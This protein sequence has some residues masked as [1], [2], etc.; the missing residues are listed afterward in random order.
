MTNETDMLAALPRLSY[1]ARQRLIRKIRQLDA[2]EG[3][4]TK[5]AS[6]DP[7]PDD[8]LFDGI[9]EVLRQRHMLIA[10][11]SLR[12]L[13]SMRVWRSF[14]E[15]SEAVRGHIER[16]LPD[17]PTRIDRQ[18]L[19]TVIARCLARRLDKFTPV[20]LAA[21]LNY[22]HL[23]LEALEDQFPGYLAT[24]KLVWILRAQHLH[25]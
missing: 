11:P 1:E 23:A 18:V 25:G 7:L 2:V 16:Q 12:Q 24:G 19:G 3:K 8:W 9:L 4:P 22:A 20:S 6:E 15:K 5:N 21:M 17:N 14:C 10:K 13:K